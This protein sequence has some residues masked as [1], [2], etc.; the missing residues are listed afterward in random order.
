MKA[1]MISIKPKWCEM[2][3]SGKKTIEVRKTRPNFET[4]FKCYIY[5]TKGKPEDLSVCPDQF[6]KVIGE[7]VCD[8]IATIG[9]SPYNHGEYVCDIENLYKKSC[10]GLE[11]VYCYISDGYGYAWHISDLAIYDK[12]KELSKFYKKCNNYF[13]SNYSECDCCEFGICTPEYGHEC[14]CHY[15]KTLTRSPRSWCYVEQLKGG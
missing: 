14:G 7:F 6:G 15:E 1:V 5:C 9:Y 10:M 12:P 8:R 4:P 3:A 2:I 11:D 13:E